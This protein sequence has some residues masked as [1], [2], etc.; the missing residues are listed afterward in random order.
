MN[1]RKIR[2]NFIDLLILLVIAAVVFVLLY[3]FVLSDRTT[4]AD[5]QAKTK[6]QY[7]IEILN[8][9]ERF[10][11]TIRKGQR[12]EDAIRRK[13][14]GTVIGVEPKPFQTVTFDYNNREEVLA[15]PEG[16]ITLYV[17]VDAE[18]DETD[19]AF[20]ADGVEIRVGQQY[21]LIF[22]DFYGVGYCT[23]LKTTGAG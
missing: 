21:S 11:E 13:S 6:I 14:V 19:G 4:A 1:K 2:F 3:V 23:S 12:V 8:V 18:V 10:S 7:V 22:P 17:T 15:S 20:T 5:D 9:D 16:R